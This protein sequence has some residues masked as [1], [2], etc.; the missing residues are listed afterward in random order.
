MP[1]LSILN[2]RICLYLSN[3]CEWRFKN[4]TPLWGDY[5][6]LDSSSKQTVVEPDWD[7]DGPRCFWLAF[8]HIF[9][10]VCLSRF[11]SA[12]WSRELFNGK[13]YALKPETFG[14]GLLNTD[15][16]LHKPHIVVPGL[17]VPQS[18]FALLAD[19]GWNRRLKL[20]CHEL[21]I[22]LPIP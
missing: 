8:C 10:N 15:L 12:I 2:P 5:G 16:S 21:H 3:K 18:E 9:A 7:L 22:F 13:E 1:P 11:C 20:S 19:S 17:A 14:G 6:S 4:Q